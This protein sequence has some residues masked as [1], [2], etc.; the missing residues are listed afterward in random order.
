MKVQPE[1]ETIAAI[2][3]TYE[4]ARFFLSGTRLDSVRKYLSIL[5]LEEFEWKNA[6]F[7][8]SAWADLRQQHAELKQDDLHR[9]FVLTRLVALSSGKTELDKSHWDKAVSMETERRRRIS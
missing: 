5:R 7:I 8:G 9:L 2:K 6:D 4:A 3:E 1:A